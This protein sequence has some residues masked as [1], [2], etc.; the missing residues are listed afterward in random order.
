MAGRTLRIGLIA[1]DG[2]GREVIPA[3][4]K[5]LESLPA[6]L[7]LNFSFV[8][9][10]AGW[11][12]FQKTGT[13]LPDKTVEVLKNECDGALF[14][15]VSSPTTKVA[16]YTSPIVALRKKLALY[17]NVRPCKTT[18]SAAFQSPTPHPID[19]VIVREN[20]EDLYVKEEKTYPDPSGEGQIAEAIKRISSKASWRIANI[21]GEIALRRQKMREQ[22]QQQQQQ[23][24]DALVTITHKSNVLSQT[25]G[26]FRSTA[27]EALSQAKFSNV[28]VEE[29]IVDS[30]V[31]KLFLQP[32]YYDVIVAPNLYGDL[33]S[34]GAAALVGSLGLVPSANVGDD[35]VIGEPCHGSA[36]DIE[37]KG[38]ANPIATIRSVGV[39]LEFLNLP[40][41]ANAV[42]A[43][44]DAN[45]AEGKFV[46]PDLG[47]TATTEQVVQDVIK[48]FCFYPISHTGGQEGSTG[49]TPAVRKAGLSTPKRRASTPA[50]L[51]RHVP[52]SSPATSELEYAQFTPLRQVLDERC[53]RR[54]RRNGLSEVV[55]DYQ[56]EKR[57]NTHLRHEIRR[58]DEEL[59][60]MR[61]Q[62]EA[63][64]RK[65]QTGEQAVQT[66]AVQSRVEEVEEELS[67]LRRSFGLDIQPT[68]ELEV[69]VSW[70]HVPR[71]VGGGPRSIG[72]RVDATLMSLELSSA[73][74]AKQDMLHSFSRT[75]RSFDTADFLNFADAASAQQQGSSHGK[76][77]STSSRVNLQEIRKQ[78]TLAKSRADDA[79]LALSALEG[80]VRALGFTQDAD[81]PASTCLAALA[82]H[83]RAIRLDLEHLMPGETA[84]SFDNAAL[85]PEMV[86]KLKQLAQQLAARD[87]ELQGLR[88]QEKSLRGNFDHAIIAAGKAQSK[89]KELEKSIDDAAE[90]TLYMRMKNQQLARDLN[91]R[92]SDVEKLQAALDKYRQEVQR[93]EA[94]ISQVEDEHKRAMATVQASA[95]GWETVASDME[96]KAAAETLG[97]RKAEESAV[98]RL[99]K[100]QE[101]EDALNKA[102]ELAEE[103]GERLQEVEERSLRHR[104]EVGQLN[105]RNSNL[106]TALTSAE[107]EIAKL[108]AINQKLEERY[109]NEVESGRQAVER[110]Q[111]EVIK[112]ATRISEQGKGYRRSSK[113]RLANWELESDD[114]PV[115]EDGL[116]MT[117]AS[118][119]STRALCAINAYQQESRRIYALSSSTW[120][121][122]GKQNMPDH[123]TRPMVDNW[124]TA[125]TP[126]SPSTAA[127]PTVTGYRTPLSRDPLP[128]DLNTIQHLASQ[129][130][131]GVR[132]T[133]M[134]RA[135]DEAEHSA[136]MQLPFLHRLLQRLYPGRTPAAAYPPLVPIMVGATS[137][138]TEAALGRL[139]APYVADAASNAFVISSD[140]CHWGSRFQYTYYVADAPSPALDPRLLHKHLSPGTHLR[141]TPGPGNPHI[142]ESIAHVDRACMCA[143]ATGEHAQFVDVL[144][145]T[146]PEA[147]E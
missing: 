35:I 51:G 78:L 113:V 108:K 122:S 95:K 53:K 64:R 145:A 3:G 55:N 13:A 117:P 30:M 10:D 79:E 7:G 11:N 21:A 120:P 123:G 76:Q 43:A 137:A 132:F 87:A 86:K 146:G 24:R 93:L 48:R 1:G 114:Y 103:T 101:L 52:A 73:R 129:S 67:R 136:E 28:K 138:A 61:Q 29:Q 22:Q 141:K 104:E 39:M 80:E 134:S 6:S 5:V 26:L 89:I 25:D 130:Q 17:A 2:I 63:A 102:K 18:L 16:G 109:R 100:I 34:D 105:V 74:Q 121:P 36:P 20:T 46:S 97:R 81:A 65:P 58:K 85:L 96:A 59:K 8:D 38:I 19:L 83:F 66:E 107:A 71:R 32:Q 91:E 50:N 115:G 119:V 92:Q 57:E 37:G 9:L 143:I 125:S 72:D 142:Y 133:H 45:L 4:K 112:A 99:A 47:G 118:T 116:P 69:D 75:S 98:K 54:I 147:D 126:G 62:L 128:L 41:A 84:I 94:L 68:Q 42:Y 56:S 111:H 88:S 135:V 40:E 49:L 33:L 110:M 127:L 31:Y 106:S 15:A 60:Q 27:R 23:Q 124:P 70:D 12:T 139:L 140:F 144:R 131:G 44:V 14:G 77:S 90:E 82:D